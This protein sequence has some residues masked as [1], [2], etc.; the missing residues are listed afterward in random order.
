MGEGY[1]CH[2]ASSG[3]GALEVLSTHAVDLVLLDIMMLAM[4]GLS[5]F[6]RLEERHPDVAVMFVTGVDDITLAVEHL[7]GGAYDYLVKPVSQRRLLQAVE[8]SLEKHRARLRAERHRT[9]LE[10]LVLNQSRALQNRVREVH[11]LNRMI[12]NGF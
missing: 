3:H 10:E 2:T 6:Q 4:T 5:L 12:Q 11:A 1:A 9:H 8:E 7:K